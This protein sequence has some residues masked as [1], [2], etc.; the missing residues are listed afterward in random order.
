MRI[1]AIYCINTKE[2]LYSRGTHDYRK[3]SDERCAIDGGLVYCRII[4]NPEDFV[5]ITLDGD[6]LLEFILSND[7]VFGNLYSDKYQEGYHG[8]FQVVDSSSLKFY[9]NLI[10]NYNDIEQYIEK[11]VQC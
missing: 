3:S 9:K 5:E 10:L 11:V 1:N 4:G 2:I 6:Y 8:R 7:Y